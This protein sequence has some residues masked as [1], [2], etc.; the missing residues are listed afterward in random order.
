MSFVL[1]FPCIF[2]EYTVLRHPPS[3]KRTLSFKRHHARSENNI[4]YLTD[5][6]R[7]ARARARARAWLWSCIRCT[8][9]EQ[10]SKTA[11]VMGLSAIGNRE[12]QRPMSA[13][14]LQSVV[15]LNELPLIS[16]ACVRISLRVRRVYV[17]VWA[18]VCAR[19]WRINCI[20]A[21]LRAAL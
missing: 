13:Y 15:T 2:I 16:T 11:R 10:I 18:R 19:A 3:A 8:P 6:P 14:R 1:F 5:F 21:W 20:P 4:L 12:H 17:C 7:F 9:S